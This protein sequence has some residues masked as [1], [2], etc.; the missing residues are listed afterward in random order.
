MGN[1]DLDNKKHSTIG[2]DRDMENKSV[3]P[4]TYKSQRKIKSL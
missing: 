2:R 4:G 3:C 1:E